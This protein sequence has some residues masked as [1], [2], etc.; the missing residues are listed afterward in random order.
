MK[1]RGIQIVV[2]LFSIFGIIIVLFLPGHTTSGDKSEPVKPVILSNLTS[3]TV[4]SI[5]IPESAEFAGQTV[6][7]TRYD[8]RERMD[9]E[10][11][12]FTFMHTSTMLM[13]KRAN[14]YFPVIEPILRENEIPDDFKYLMTIESNL[15]PEA[16][17]PVGAAG[18]WQFMPAT[19]GEFGLEVNKNVDERYNTAKA[20]KAACKYLRAAYV[21]Y[22]DWLSV[23][24]AYNGG[25]RR[26]TSELELQKAE[27]A[28]DLRLVEET[29][30]YMFRLLAAKQVFDHPQQFGFLIKKEHLYPPFTYEEVKVTKN[31]PSLAEFA[32]QKDITYAQLKDAN[33]WLRQLS[34]ENKSGR[35]YVFHIPTRKSMNYDPK[36]TPVH[37]KRWVV[38]GL[39]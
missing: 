20:T 29:S 23:A 21:K 34:L 16:L 10:L 14:R 37:D 24:A 3:Y 11:M 39:N 5:D 27:K 17:S 18:L 15:N 1:N 22:G 25:Q 32:K 19:A 33:P 12:A 36:K 30:R 31:I 4:A 2:I 26:I 7:L 35:T 13:I 28:I 9:R 6:D 8:C 38:D